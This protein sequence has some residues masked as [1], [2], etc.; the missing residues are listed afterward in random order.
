VPGG[1]SLCS[2]GLFTFACD[3]T[4]TCIAGYCCPGPQSCGSTCCQN[5]QVCK[6]GVCCPPTQAC[7][8]SCCG[9]GQTCS[10]GACCSGGQIGCGS[11]TCCPGGWACA[12]GNATGNFGCCPPEWVTVNGACCSADYPCPQPG[13]NC[14]AKVRGGFLGLGSPVCP[15]STVV[16]FGG[17]CCTTCGITNGA[18]QGLCVALLTVDPEGY[19]ECT[20]QC[21]TTNL[22]CRGACLTQG[23]VCP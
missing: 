21:A 19:A 18:C 16:T 13:G 6:G 10:N 15:S 23:K 17:D 7:G 11:G 20:S 8:S 2:N 22:A 5:G 1:G 3:A 4:Q 12:R 14:E 9:P